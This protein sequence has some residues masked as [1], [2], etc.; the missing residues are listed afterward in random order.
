MKI[1]SKHCFFHLYALR[2]ED[3]K[4]SSDYIFVITAHL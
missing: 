3:D 2:K 1:V 4:T